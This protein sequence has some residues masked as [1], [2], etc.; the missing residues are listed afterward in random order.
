MFTNQQKNQNVLD[1]ILS[2]ETELVDNVIIFG[3]PADVIIIRESLQNLIRVY[4]IT[5]K[6]KHARNYSPKPS[7][8][9]YSFRWANFEQLNEELD[10]IDFQQIF[11]DLNTQDCFILLT[12]KIPECSRRQISQKVIQTEHKPYGLISMSNKQRVHGLLFSSSW[13]NQPNTRQNKHTE[14]GS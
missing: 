10:D 14:W 7:R 13:E 4:M 12:Y 2:T 11:E 9:N 8:H 1:L 3:K 5:F 6:N